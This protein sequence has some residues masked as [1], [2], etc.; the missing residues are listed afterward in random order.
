MTQRTCTFDGCDQPHR[1]RGWCQTHYLRWKKHGDPSWN[2]RRTFEQRFFE[3]VHK[4]ETGC[5]EW[6]AFL[7]H[8]GYGKFLGADGRVRMAHRVWYEHEHGT[9]S[10]RLQLDHLCRNRKCVNP[11]HLDPVVAWVNN[12]R[13]E[14]PSAQHLRAEECPRGHAYD[15]ANTYWRPDGKGR[16]CRQCRREADAR[17]TGRKVA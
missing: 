5:W 2:G 17:R 3:K 11:E 1:A 14:S 16:G 7:D 8:N 6:T 9:L 15:D 4:A 13:S 12:A 10:E